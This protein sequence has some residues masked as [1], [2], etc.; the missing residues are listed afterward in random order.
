[1]SNPSLPAPTS[2]GGG[3]GAT[4]V[5]KRA[6]TTLLMAYVFQI[7]VSRGAELV[8]PLILV[9]KVMMYLEV[10]RI[11]AKERKDNEVPFFRSL[12]WY[13]LGVVM[14]FSAG[15]ALRDP[16]SKTFPQLIPVFEHHVMT[17]FGLTVVG[18]LMFVMSLKRGMYRYQFQQFTWMCMTLIFI[19]GQGTL[20]LQNMRRGMFWFLLPASCVVHNDVWAY[21]C[22]KLF[23]RTPLLRLSP[24]KTL[25]GFL[26]SWFFTMIWAFWFS[27]FM[28]QL[29]S[30]YCSKIDFHTPLMCERDPIFDKTVSVPYPL[31]KVMSVL[32]LWDE[33]SSSANKISPVQLH[34][35][36]FGA[37]AS[38]IAPFGGFFASGLKRA[39]KLKDFGDLIPGHGG[40]TDR[41]D[42]QIIMGSFT[43]MY[44]NF[45]IFPPTWDHSIN[46]NNNNMNNNYGVATG[47]CGNSVSS[48]NSISDLTKCI[49]GLSGD[50]KATLFAN[51]QI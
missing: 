7:I 48:L 40:M 13:F 31:N 45:V 27:S 38:L 42:C 24:K 12:Q 41:M 11:S 51:L 17:C 47:I 10:L 30:L 20:Q 28:S 36:I 25:E 26:G 5:V 18:F 37:F 34:A 32:F 49:Q 29:P 16:L 9:I 46:N 23:G 44:L 2:S 1:M 3:G 21:I 39:F 15:T 14:W 33:N 6:V 19:V 50:Q 43:F 35:L 4:E 22:G 8:M